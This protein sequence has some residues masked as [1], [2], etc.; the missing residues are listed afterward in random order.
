MH[1]KHLTLAAAL[2]V[3]APLA[4]AQSDPK[5]DP[6]QLMTMSRTTAQKMD[7][8]KDGMVSKQEF[9]KAMEDKWNAMDTGRKGMVPIEQVARN[10]LF[11]SNQVG[12]P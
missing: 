7:V 5:I 11:L 4:I 12:A 2:A 6:D 10:M 8:N 3:L 1:L 9:M